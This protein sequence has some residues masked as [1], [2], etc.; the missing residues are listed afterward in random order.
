MEF[1]TSTMTL[2]EIKV[3][4]RALVFQHHPDVG[5]DTATMQR[6]NAAYTQA[7]ANRIRKEKP[8]KTDREYTNLDRYAEHVRQAI[9][10][11]IMLEG[12]RIE[13]IGW[14]V[15]LTGSTYVHREALKAAGYQWSKSKKAWFYAGSPSLNRVPMTLDAIRQYHGSELVKDIEEK[16]ALRAIEVGKV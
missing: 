6:L 11:V 5:G 13:V 7:I 9:E 15:W 16:S 3:A 2:D 4:Y 8:G 14:W 1:F 12:I 10:A